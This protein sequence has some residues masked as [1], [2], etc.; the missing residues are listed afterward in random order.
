MAD[1]LIP[2]TLSE[3]AI[4]EVKHIMLN[5]NIP[6]GYGLRV[7]VKGGGGCGGF[8]YI[9]GFDT[10]KE[11]DI[12]FEIGGIPIFVEKKHTMYLLGI[13]VDFYEGAD[14]RGFTFVKG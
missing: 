3:K 1:K 9:L 4:A 6:G 12:D 5:K 11:N 8:N 2:I 13:E 7:G 14:A 10:Q